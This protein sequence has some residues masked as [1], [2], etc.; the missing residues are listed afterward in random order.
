M[1]DKNKGKKIIGC[2]KQEMLNV[3]GKKPSCTIYRTKNVTK[4]LLI[5][6][7]TKK[8]KKM[9][10]WNNSAVLYWPAQCLTASVFEKYHFFY[11]TKIK[12]TLKIN[13]CEWNNY[14]NNK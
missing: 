14:I 4:G 5:S 8:N 2:T 9:S 13:E 6:G 12:I 11:K 7:V 10:Y 3:V 1:G